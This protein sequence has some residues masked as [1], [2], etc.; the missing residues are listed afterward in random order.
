MKMTRSAYLDTQLLV[1]L[2][3]IT[4]PTETGCSSLDN[5]A[6]G[7]SYRSLRLTCFSRQ[8]IKESFNHLV[9]G[10]TPD[11]CVEKKHHL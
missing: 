5:E 7:R 11:Y 4:Y 6:T 8:D 1:V 2:R 3:H 9:G 10:L